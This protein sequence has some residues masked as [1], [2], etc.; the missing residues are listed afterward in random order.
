MVDLSNP[1]SDTTSTPIKIDKIDIGN[2]IQEAK[3]AGYSDKAIVDHLSDKHSEFS[4]AR[5]AGY[6]DKDILSHFDVKVIPQSKE[7][8][9]AI[10]SKQ[11]ASETPS[12][13]L[14]G[15]SLKSEKGLI[16]PEELI[17]NTAE[18]GL[19][20]VGVNPTVAS[21]GGYAADIA[22]GMAGQKVA[23]AGLKGAKLAS[24]AISTGSKVASKA[25]S[26]YVSDT[27]SSHLSK[28]GPKAFSDNL[29]RIALKFKYPGTD[30]AAIG[31]LLIKVADKIKTM[32]HKQAAEYLAKGGPG[33]VES[34]VWEAMMDKIQ[35]SIKS[36]IKSSVKEGF[37]EGAAMP[38]K[39]LHKFT[40]KI[41]NAVASDADSTT[42][43]IAS[44]MMTFGAHWHVGLPASVTA[45]VSMAVIKSAQALANKGKKAALEKLGKSA[46]DLHKEWDDVA[47]SMKAESTF[48]RKGT[49]A[50]GKPKYTATATT[51]QIPMSDTIKP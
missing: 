23:S 9:N 5:G 30:T 29:K 6:S 17:S 34:Q 51:K 27:I 21:V 43:K 7:A 39:L 16:Q 47:E 41:V 8:F 38:T 25:A 1:V 31:P 37:V 50:R 45:G 10:K 32:T 35:D 19:L 14:H 42:K 36:S 24:E 18:E 33:S 46:K 15:E 11:L 20:K 49:D 2:K 4:T 44:A 12:Q 48:T 26:D 22:T 3:V 13:K 40:D 28:V